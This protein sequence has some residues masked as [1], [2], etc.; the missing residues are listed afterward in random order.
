MSERERLAQ[1]LGEHRISYSGA[2]ACGGRAL[3]ANPV[4]LTQHVADALLAAGFGDKQ[5]AWEEAVDTVLDCPTLGDY[6]LNPYRTNANE[7]TA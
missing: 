5:A 2:C 4:D 3:S 1:A 7:E 6:D